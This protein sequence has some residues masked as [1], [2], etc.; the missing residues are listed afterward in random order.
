MQ[1]HY[2]TCKNLIMFG[3][4]AVTFSIY[5]SSVLYYSRCKLF[6]KVIDCFS[7]AACG[8]IGNVDIIL[9]C[10]V[11]FF[12]II[13]SDHDVIFNILDCKS[14]YIPQT[15]TSVLREPND[16]YSLSYYRMIVLFITR[17]EP[18]ERLLIFVCL[19]VMFI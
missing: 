12:Q 11:R 2:R 13:L 19:F 14:R 4:V 17:L 9:C 5:L 3:S 1:R 16:N 7:N 10:L 18:R 6:S 8:Q 15:R